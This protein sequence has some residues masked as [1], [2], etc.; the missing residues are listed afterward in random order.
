M[1][2]IRLLH[3]IDVPIYK[4]I[5]TQLRFMIEAGQLVDG[6]RLPS[7]R[8]LAA[9]LHIN[10]N[11]AAKAY[12]E[13]RDAGLVESKRRNGMVV[14][15]AGGARQQSLL[16]ESADGVMS[17]AVEACFALGLSAEEISAL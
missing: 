6:D 10:R 2:D 13:L 4:Q 3:T 7:S 16:R 9:N 1:T 5:V 14:R 11:T 15:N 12:A 8:L 17:K